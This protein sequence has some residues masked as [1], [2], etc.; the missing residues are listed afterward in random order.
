MKFV[1][2]TRDLR[3]FIGNFI[4]ELAPTNELADT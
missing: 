4:N 2:A 3:K 1:A